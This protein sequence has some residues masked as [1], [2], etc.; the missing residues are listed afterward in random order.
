[1]TLV[2][3]NVPLARRIMPAKKTP[4]LWCLDVLGWSRPYI[5]SSPMTKHEK[6]LLKVQ[7]LSH[8]LCDARLVHPPHECLL[9]RSSPSSLCIRWGCLVCLGHSCTFYRHPLVVSK[10][11]WHPQQ[12]LFFHI[13]ILALLEIAT[14]SPAFGHT[15][16]LSESRRDGCNLTHTFVG[17]SIRVTPDSTSRPRWTLLMRCIWMVIPFIRRSFNSWFAFL[18]SRLRHLTSQG[19]VLR[20][21]ASSG[22]TRK[23][24]TVGCQLA[25]NTLLGI[26]RNMHFFS[27]AK[28]FWRIFCLPTKELPDDPG[29]EILKRN[30]KSVWSAV[31]F[32]CISTTID[33]K[34]LSAINLLNLHVVLQRLG[35]QNCNFKKKIATQNP[36]KKHRADSIY[37]CF[38][39]TCSCNWYI[40]DPI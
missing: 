3:L 34:I 37:L 29:Y 20:R 18:A 16:W 9:S 31:S 13:E 8:S 2:Y 6:L 24:G 39:P 36:S 32:P 17:G 12:S 1:M 21:R 22:W 7:S 26:I 4:G 14:V 10:N 35:I 33:P 15:F 27:P 40:S 11:I 19:G 30:A 25:D 28:D 5:Q 38:F 23:R